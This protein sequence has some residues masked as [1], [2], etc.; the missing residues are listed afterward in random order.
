MVSAVRLN[1]NL[2]KPGL[3]AL[4]RQRRILRQENAA[5]NRRPRRLVERMQRV[6]TS[7]DQ[8]SSLHRHR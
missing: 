7:I 6:H 5:L 4:F 8:R 3:G 2:S 1:S